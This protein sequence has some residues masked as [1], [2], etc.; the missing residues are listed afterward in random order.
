MKFYTLSLILAF[1]LTG[2]THSAQT[3]VATQNSTQNTKDNEVQASQVLD[4]NGVNAG[5]QTN[6]AAADNTETELVN[7]HDACFHVTHKVSEMLV[8]S[9]I[10]ALTV[11]G[12]DLWVA[13]TPAGDVKIF[14]SQNDDVENR[15]IA[16]NAQIACYEKLDSHFRLGWIA[17]NAQDGTFKLEIHDFNGDIVENRDELWLATTRG[18][19]PDAGTKCAFLGRR[20]LIVVGTRPRGDHVPLHGF[21]HLQSRALKLIEGTSEHVPLLESAIQKDGKTQ[22]L[23]RTVERDGDNKPQWPFGVY[24]LID[25]EEEAQLEKV[26][27]ADFIVADADKW[28]SFDKSGCLLTENTRI[29]PNKPLQLREI[30]ALPGMCEDTVCVE[31]MTYQENWI[32]KIQA[33]SVELIAIPPKMR[34]FEKTHRATNEWL[35]V[36]MDE[37]RPDLTDGLEFVEIDRNCL[38]I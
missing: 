36:T 10:G 8:V 13:Q 26:L 5:A 35:S 17:R 12:K 20:D 18:F 9:S 15:T 11:D 1:F 16:Q 29:C 23:M 6:S 27:G 34:L 4:N 21:F 37:V 31:M 33:D 38:G 30:R 28:L 2:C 3:S 32:A 22:L 19:V 14:K 7:T 24:H 25:A